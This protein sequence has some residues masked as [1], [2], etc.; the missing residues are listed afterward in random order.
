M[1]QVKII[2]SSEPVYI[3]KQGVT[4]NATLA[5][6]Q[7]A[8][9]TQKPKC[10]V[11]RIA[12]EIDF[13]KVRTFLESVGRNSR[14]SRATYET[15]LKHLQRLFLSALNSSSYIPKTNHTKNCQQKITMSAK[16]RQRGAPSL[17][18]TVKATVAYLCSLQISL[19]AILAHHCHYH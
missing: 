7:E 8:I 10:K 18:A 17:L 16:N 13:P 2:N 9:S 6:S 12:S 15:G 1:E 4:Q 11:L 3:R 19:E 14:N 5:T